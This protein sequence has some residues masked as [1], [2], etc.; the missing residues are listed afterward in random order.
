MNLICLVL[1]LVVGAG[2]G[3]QTQPKPQQI[4]DSPQ[5][6]VLS[7]AGEPDQGLVQFDCSRCSAMTDL[8][9]IAS[10]DSCGNAGCNYFIFT[11]LQ[12]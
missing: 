6:D 1:S 8:L 12:A 4:T 5:R 3:A 10:R 11:R 9:F 2:A 7:R